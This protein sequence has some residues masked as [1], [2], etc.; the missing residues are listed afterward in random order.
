M[1]DQHSNVLAAVYV[2]SNDAT[3]NEVL[4]FG[5]RPDGKLAPFGQ[6]ATGG[7]GTGKPHLPSQ[8]SIVSQ[9]RRPA[10]ARR[11]RRQR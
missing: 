5:R 7:H 9:R 10:A 1:T 11:E 8:S 4:A 2:Q 6:F 3:N